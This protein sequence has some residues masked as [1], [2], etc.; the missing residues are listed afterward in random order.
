MPYTKKENIVVIAVTEK[1]A[2]MASYIAEKIGAEL[3]LREGIGKEVFISK[4]YESLSEHIKK[5][6]HSYKAWIFVMSL[7]I[8]NR[9]ISGLITNKYNDPAVVTHDEMGR[10]V[11]STL[12]GH[13]GGANEIAYL[14][15]SYTGADP[16]ITTASEANK[17][18]TC[19]VGFR[20]GISEKELYVA[21]QDACN[22]CSITTKHL[23]CIS[24]AWIKLQDGILDRVGKQL[25]IPVR[26]IPKWLI[27]YVYRT[28]KRMK[29]SRLV[30]NKIGVEGVAEPCALLS[31]RNTEILLPKT[32]YKGITVSIAK[33]CL[34]HDIDTG[35][36]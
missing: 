10:Y 31:G 20:K 4:R 32:L 25:D 36:N 17:I 8:V 34:L 15:S 33:E 11:I 7:G 22:R 19:G 21:I 5:Y 24:T 12:S 6:F 13:E 26:Y 18:Y 14:V 1:G 23:R 16:V 28:D 3:H 30:K 27:E 2:R 29:K 35:W 9:V